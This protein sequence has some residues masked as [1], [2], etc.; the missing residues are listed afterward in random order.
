MGGVAFD[1]PVCGRCG[2]WHPNPG[3]L[4]RLGA[5]IGFLFG[6]L[7]LGAAGVVFYF[8]PQNFVMWGFMGL[9]GFLICLRP[10]GKFPNT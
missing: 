1:A 6:L 2:G 5:I 9:M 3:A 8:T 7:I 4:T 10:Y